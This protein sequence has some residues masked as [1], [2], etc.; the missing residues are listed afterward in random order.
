MSDPE[1]HP[2]F[3]EPSNHKPNSLNTAIDN[4]IKLLLPISDTVVE[5]CVVMGGLGE[6]DCEMFYAKGFNCYDS[7]I[8]GL[9]FAPLG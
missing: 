4:G 3:R 8:T 6:S 2:E 5:I 9:I 7:R 1:K